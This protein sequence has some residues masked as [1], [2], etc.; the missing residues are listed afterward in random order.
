MEFF[1]S[2]K[3][4]ANKKI[5]E[6]NDRELFVTELLFDTIECDAKEAYNKELKSISE[7]RTKI[8]ALLAWMNFN[9]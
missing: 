9:I 4:Q 2:I 7:W 3:E 6:L 8:F 1:E 5:H